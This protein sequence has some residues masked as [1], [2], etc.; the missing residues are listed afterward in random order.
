MD[1]TIEPLFRFNVVSAKHSKK[2]QNVKPFTG[3]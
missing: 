1:G 2:Q 3:N